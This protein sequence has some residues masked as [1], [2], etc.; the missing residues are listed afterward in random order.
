MNRATLLK[1]AG[2]ARRP[3]SAR[4]VGYTEWLLQWQFIGEETV[5]FLGGPNHAAES[6][7][8]MWAAAA[9]PLPADDVIA[10]VKVLLRAVPRGAPQ[11]RARRQLI[12]WLVGCCDPTDNGE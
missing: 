7:V 10:E 2:L 6:L 4:M 11:Y 9:P 8:R 12:R 3:Q 5:A 1:R